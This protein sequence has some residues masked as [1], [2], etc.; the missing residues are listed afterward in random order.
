MFTQTLKTTLILPVLA[1]VLLAEAPSKNQAVLMAM[2]AN[3]K[4]V[5]T[6]RWMQKTTVFRKGNPTG[7]KVDE[8]RFDANGQP[9]RI[10]ISMPEEKRVGPLMARKVADVKN[11][12]HETMQLAMRYASPQELGQAIRTGE[13]WEGQGTLRLRSRG[14]IRPLDE[15]TAVINTRTFLPARID[16]K[17]QNDGSPVIIAID[18]EQLPN[19]PSVMTR[20]TVQIPDDDLVVRV[21]SFDFLRLAGPV[22]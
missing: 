10:T 22:H 2:A 19:G 12:V 13:M 7:T 6:Y 15:M 14:V 11:T 3:G 20:M 16:I 17:T 4:Q 8:V 9:H 1:S 18:Y 21:E 5:V